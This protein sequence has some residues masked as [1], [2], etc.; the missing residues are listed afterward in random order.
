MPAASTFLI[1]IVTI[2]LLVVRRYLAREHSLEK[3]EPISTTYPA[4]A[5]VDIYVP[6]LPTQI[7]APQQKRA[8]IVATRQ[9]PSARSR[10]SAT[11]FENGTKWH[12]RN[13][14]SVS[15]SC[16]RRQPRAHSSRML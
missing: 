5:I 12:V 11:G 16:T 2:A 15:P 14:N 4:V 3:R 6:A 1:T 8:R 7:V 9:D 10:K 13:G